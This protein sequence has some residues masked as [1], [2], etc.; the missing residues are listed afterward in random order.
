MAPRAGQH[1]YLQFDGAALITDVY[2]NGQSAGHHEGGY[3]AFRFDVTPYL[4]A[5]QNVVAV[6]VDNTRVPQIAPLD[7]DFNIFGGLYRGVSLIAVSDVHIDLKDHGGPGVYMAVKSLSDSR[8]DLT[9][10]VLLVNDGKA[11]QAVVRV[12]VLDADGKTVATA[13]RRQT[14]TGAATAELPL[15]V[16]KPHL[17]QGRADPYLYHAEVTVG[18][19]VVTVPLGLR[20]VAVD[21]DKGLILNGKPYEV[22][23]VN[24]QQPG[25]PGKGTAVSDDEIDADMKMIA[26][27]GA[28]GVRLAHMQH[29][30]RVY[31][32]ADSMGFV[33][34]TEVPFVG[35]VTAGDAFRDNLVEQMRELVAQNYNH[36]S[37]IMWG[38]GNEVWKDSPEG[39]AVLAA[40]QTTA[41]TLDPARPTVY[42]HCCQPDDSATAL[43]ADVT[44]YN[45]YFGWY[46]G[47]TKDFGAWADGLHAKFPKRAIGVS[48][49]GA[50]GSILAQED[51][52]SRPQTTSFWH[53]EQYQA[54]F[55][56][57]YWNQMK[58]R[59]F[60]WSDFIWVAFDFPSYGRNEGDRPS[61]NDKGL[62]SEDRLVKKDAYYWYQANWSDRLMLHIASPRY[63]ARRTREVT[64]RVYANVPE[65]RLQLNGESL[66]AQP[67]TDHV[68]TWKVSL[69]DGDNTIEAFAGKDLHDAVH[70][71]YTDAVTR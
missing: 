30:Q 24:M 12:K 50:G 27:L 54:Q 29:P 38:L 1:Y 46:S 35:N 4:K 41:K 32:D 33:I 64:V 21:P 45:R 36:P 26:D 15:S 39:N 55:H 14:V 48:E 22:H 71:Q 47:D 61:V 16:K 18:D 57:Q 28:T 62:V 2:V 11:G 13:S 70:W 58:T 9:A 25:R 10:R 31:D 6:R 56:E 67:V 23:G 68:A 69:K 60:L 51:P 63:T 65:V 7:G 34:T 42:S 43:H 53:P 40:L 19:D 44:S 3:A 66:P 8:A 52:P 37:V 20:T 49:Y 17:W 59:P 5:G